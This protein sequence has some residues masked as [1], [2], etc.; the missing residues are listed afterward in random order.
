L[1][2]AN[3]QRGPSAFV[4]YSP[5]VM[6]VFPMSIASSIKGLPIHVGRG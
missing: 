2:E 6:L 5:I 1:S 3:L 4:I